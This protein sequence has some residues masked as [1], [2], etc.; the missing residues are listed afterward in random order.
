MARWVPAVALAVAVLAV[1]LAAWSLVRPAQAGTAPSTTNAA[2]A[3]ARACAAYTTVSGAVSLQTHANLG[4]D[5]IA[6]QAVAA[7][8]RLAMAAGSSYLLANLDPNTPGPVADAVRSLADNLQGVA[9]YALNGVANN[10]PDQTARLNA[11]QADST[12]LSELC[13]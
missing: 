9:I 11:A 6:V 2:D 1:A 5:P 12:K 8:A 3:E 10:D 13:T 4:P 7:N